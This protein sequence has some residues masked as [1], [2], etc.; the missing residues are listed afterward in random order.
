VNPFDMFLPPQLRAAP[1]S[2]IAWLRKKQRSRV[3]KALEAVRL[4]RAFNLERCTSLIDDGVDVG[5]AD[6][7]FLA[8]LRQMEHALHEALKPAA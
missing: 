1:S 5:D 2:A 8:S 6:K 7:Q 3:R 4:V